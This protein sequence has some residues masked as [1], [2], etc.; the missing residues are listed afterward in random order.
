MRIELNDGWEF[1]PKYND[2]L[3]API[4]KVGDTTEVRIP[5]SVKITPFNYFNN[6]DYE[7][8]S[9]YRKVIS[10][11]REWEGKRLILTFDA[12]AHSAEVRI[13]GSY[14]TEHHCGYTAFRCEITDLE[15][16]RREGY[17]DILLAV[18][19]WKS[20]RPAL[21]YGEAMDAL[22]FMTKVKYDNGAVD[23]G[24]KVVVIGGGNT[25]MDVSRAALRVKGVKQV[26]LVY[27]RTKRY[28]PAEEEELREAVE[29]GVL[30]RELLSPVGWKDGKLECS[31]MKLGEPDEGGRRSPVDTGRKELIE[32]DS[33]ITAV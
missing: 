6:Q 2:E 19:A 3:G 29:D 27:R 13:N 32:C 18:G 7:M 17:T 30:F 4:Y 21:A 22:E 14:V 12:V 8:V 11:P 26:S 16:L 23:L 9:G 25:A 28:M 15:A 20:G 24:E 5:H 1:T 31:V 10:L 33:V